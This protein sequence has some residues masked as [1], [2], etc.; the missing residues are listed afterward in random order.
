[1]IKSILLSKT[2]FINIISYA[3][4]KFNS[5]DINDTIKLGNT[6]VI[7]KELDNIQPLIDYTFAIDNNK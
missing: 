1:M 3:I 2:E 6:G 7:I 4:A 5:E